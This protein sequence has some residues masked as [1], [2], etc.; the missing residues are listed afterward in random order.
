LLRSVFEPPVTVV[1]ILLH[2]G[3]HSGDSFGRLLGR[4]RQGLR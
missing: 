2:H 1:L 3:L 4:D